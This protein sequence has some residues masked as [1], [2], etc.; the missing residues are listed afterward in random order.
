MSIKNVLFTEKSW[1]TT[2]QFAKVTKQTIKNAVFF[3][4]IKVACVVR[5]D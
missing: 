2:V 4:L 5:A 1:V 3:F